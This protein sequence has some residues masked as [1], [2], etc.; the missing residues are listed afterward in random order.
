M[1]FFENEVQYGKIRDAWVLMLGE[2]ASDKDGT[3][4]VSE[5]L[6]KYGKLDLDSLIDDDG[7]PKL[8]AGWNE[9][10]LQKDPVQGR[11]DFS[12]LKGTDLTKAKL[13]ILTGLGLG[14]KEGLKAAGIDDSYLGDDG[15]PIRTN[16]VQLIDD[17]GYLRGFN[18]D[19]NGHHTIS[20]VQGAQI[21]VF[22]RYDS[23]GALK[24]LAIVPH[25]MNVPEVDLADADAVGNGT[26][27]KKFE[28]VLNAV[29]NL[30]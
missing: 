4:K 16:A 18:D 8:P 9:V 6:T 13:A 15:K 14:D 1:P 27:G 2:E 12:L 29:R 21:K 20:L 24:V 30:P 11:V 25:S 17:Q 26:Y 10:G 19:G 7:H 3:K 23:S 5:G 22:G 28:Y